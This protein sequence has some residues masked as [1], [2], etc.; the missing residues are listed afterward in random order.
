VDRARLTGIVAGDPRHNADEESIDVPRYL[1]ALRRGAWLVAL[2]VIPLTAAVLV[3][4]LVLPKTYS[5]V[6]SLVLEEQSGAVGSD[7]ETSTQRLATIRRLLTTRE[8]L[9]RAAARLPGETADTLEKKVSASVDDVASIV[10]VKAT[11]GDAAGAAAIANGVAAAFLAR[12]RATDRERVS[13]TRRDLELALT[14]LRASGASADEIS[15]VRDRLGELSLTEVTADDLQVAEAARPA[16]RPDSPKPVQNTLLAAFAALFLAVLAALGRDFMAPRVT[17][18]RQFEGLT[19]LTPLAVLPASRRRR[20]RQSQAAEAYQV[21]AASVR[22]QLSESRRVVVVTSAH[23]GDER[24]PVVAGLGRALTGSGVPT[25]LV[26]ADLR[27]PM[28]HKE[29]D[30]P[31]GPGVGEVLDRLEHDPAESADELIAAATRAHERPG[32]GELRALPS[33]GPSQHPAALLSGE[34]LG[35]MFSELNRSEYRYVV[36]EAPPL[37][38]PI[39]GQLVSRFADAV[40]VVCHLD[41]LSPNDATELGDVVARLDPP[42]LGAVLVGGTNVRYSLPLSV[43]V[44]TPAGF[45]DD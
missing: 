3:L 38:G 18:P 42:V 43:P 22:L 16:K 35:T 25:L 5:A 27:H 12:R 32:R 10:E 13:R 21:L 31:A 23:A 9:D 44:R 30:V 45:P 36:V 29:L 11:D 14:R 8:V 24:A 28:L 34:A 1:S 2:I 39:D 7:A 37:L 6:N 33:G 15:A 17:G 26:S 4:S 40:L 19:G 41:R 20:R